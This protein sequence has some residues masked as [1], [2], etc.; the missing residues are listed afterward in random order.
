[1]AETV[2]LPVHPLGDL[3]TLDRRGVRPADPTLRL[4]VRRARPAVQVMARRGEGEAVAKA[5]GIG[6]TPSQAS[7]GDGFTALP[8]RP[9][10]WV[11]LADDGVPEAFAARIEAMIEGSGYVSQQSDA[12][13]C[14]RVSGA[15]ALTFL[16]RGCRLDLERAAPGSCAQTPMAQVGVLLHVVE[17]RTV[18][19]HVAN[20]YA[21]S[22]WHWMTATALQFDHAIETEA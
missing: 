2:H 6:A 16:S 12:R 13:A 20:G 5:L 11:L 10:Q 22:F 7:G 14:F 8:L 18:D 9:G 1:M 21:R 3:A 4:T 15:D 19:L 17:A